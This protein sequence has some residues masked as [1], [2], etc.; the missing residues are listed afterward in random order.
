[1]RKDSVGM[2]DI[3][4]YDDIFSKGPGMDPR[5]EVPYYW[6]PQTVSGS[7]YA[8]SHFSHMLLRRDG[9]IC[10]NLFYYFRD[11]IYD[12]FDKENIPYNECMRACLNL[13]YHVPGVVHTD[14]HIDSP[15][16][17]HVVILYLNETDGNT[18]VYENQYDGVSKS[19]IFD[20]CE[21]ELK[22]KE[23]HNPKKGKIICFDGSHYHA[24]RLPS[25]GKI[26]NVCVFNISY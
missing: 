10:S 26:R 1:M 2:V 25:P 16:N 6:C 24:L 14:V 12:Y 7:R 17:H 13:T 4:L 18:I 15:L 19:L 8:Y 3:R 21:D 5:G 22:I 11:L 20:Q 23:E 9:K